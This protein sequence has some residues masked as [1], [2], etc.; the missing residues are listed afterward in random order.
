MVTASHASVNP[1]LPLVTI[2]E[3]CQVGPTCNSLFSHIDFEILVLRVDRIAIMLQ[4][5]PI[6]NSYIRRHLPRRKAL[7][8][9]RLD[10]VYGR[11]GV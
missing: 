5:R 2:R 9:R 11:L 3:I 7:F 1:M 10:G 4:R 8:H 6:G